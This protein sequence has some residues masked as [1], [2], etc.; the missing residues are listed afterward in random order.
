MGAKEDI[1][2]LRDIARDMDR[3]YGV[4]NG[5]NG[6][7]LRGIADRME[8]S[9]AILSE[10][11]SAHWWSCVRVNKILSGDDDPGEQTNKQYL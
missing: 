8:R 3:E 5:C 4:W 9:I 1:E 10:P 7:F 11:E 2:E 6:D